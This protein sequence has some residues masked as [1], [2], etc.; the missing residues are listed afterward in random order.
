MISIKTDES[1]VLRLY[2]K[3]NTQKLLSTYFRCPEQPSELISQLLSAGV[4]DRNPRVIISGS[5]IENRSEV[6]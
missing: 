2:K 3:K 1:E 6:N 5:W 4:S